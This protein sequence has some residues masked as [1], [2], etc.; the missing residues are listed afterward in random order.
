MEGAQDLLVAADQRVDAAA[1]GEVGEVLGEGLE[2]IA[3]RGAAAPARLLVLVVLLV[4]GRLGGAA[5]A[6]VG[7]IEAG[8]AVGDVADHVEPGDPLALQHLD[9]VGVPLVE[10]RH[11]DVGPGELVPADA[12]GA[13]GGERED[14]LDAQGEARLAAVVL[15]RFEL[16]GEVLG[17][18]LAHPV[19]V[20]A[21]V[22]EHLGGLVVEG[23]GIEKVLQARVFMTHP[24]RLGDGDGEG[25]LQIVG[26]FHSSSFPSAG[27]AVTLSGM[28]LARASSV[29][30]ATLVSAT[31]LE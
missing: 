9:G 23:Q 8:D 20:G 10:H 18:R 29:T 16:L 1:A 17:E 24:S 5:A 13:G 22:L 19:E 12:V 28:P 14:A 27:S 2:G 7:G 30:S 31:S 6:E 4:A 25:D 26:D 21:G 15:Q 3:L 11:Q